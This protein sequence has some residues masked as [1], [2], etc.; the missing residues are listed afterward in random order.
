[1]EKNHDLHF[2]SFIK[3]VLIQKNSHKT[4]SSLLCIIE[5]NTKYYKNFFKVFFYFYQVL[6]PIL[7]Q[8]N[9]YLGAA[10]VTIATKE[11]LNSRS[12]RQVSWPDR[13]E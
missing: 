1:M 3:H 9:T 12:T 11:L 8:F 5:Y 6:E 7:K 13:L 2:F 10:T 4:S